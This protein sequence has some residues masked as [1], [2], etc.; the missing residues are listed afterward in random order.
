MISVNTTI[1]TLCKSYC[2]L[3]LLS[4]T[5]HTWV[6]VLMISHAVFSGDSINQELIDLNCVTALIVAADLYSFHFVSVIS[7]I[8]AFPPY[9]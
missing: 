1:C 7:V 3:Y 4:S 8:C 5:V 2:F 9:Q 6:R